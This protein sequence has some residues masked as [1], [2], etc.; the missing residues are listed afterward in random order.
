MLEFLNPKI[1]GFG[2]DLSDLSIKIVNLKKAGDE[3]AL[4]SFCRQEIPEGAIDQGEIKKEEDLIGTIKEAV[5]NIKGEPLK[6]RYCIVSLPE[7]VSFVRMVKMPL[8]N[9]EELAEAIKWELEA[10]IPLSREEIYYD[11][12]IIEQSPSVS[13]VHQA[14]HLDVLIGVLPKKTVEPYLEVLKKAGLRPSIFEIEPVAPARALLKD[15]LAPEP[16]MTIAFG[17]KRTSLLI[18]SGQTI[19]F[20][21]SLPF[22]NNSVIENLSEKLNIGKDQ[23]LKIKLETGLNFGQPQSDVFRALEP[24][25]NEL[26]Q[27]IQSYVDFYQEHIP[28]PDGA[29]SKISKILLCGGGANLDGLPEF[30]SNNLKMAIEIGNPWINIFK[31][32]KEISGLPPSESLAYTTALGLALRGVN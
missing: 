27:K 6:T 5:K 15:G 4:A 10:Q 31:K 9:K 3:F 18:F 22:S 28:V 16:L 24:S 25:L 7:T 20:T 26:A 1:C 17:A 12:Q 19:F 2:I 13:L 23:A 21:T 8:M 30:L 32:P 11:W 29:K 14:D